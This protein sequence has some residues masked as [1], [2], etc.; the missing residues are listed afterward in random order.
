MN[1]FPIAAGGSLFGSAFTFVVLRL[2]FRRKLRKWS[3]SHE[4]WKRWKLSSYVLLPFAADVL[5]ISRINV[6]RLVPSGC[7]GSSSDHAHSSISLPAMGVLECPLC[8]KSSLYA[9]SVHG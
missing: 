4:T 9:V 7:E 2:L 6:K 1:G 5:G 8:R 3:E